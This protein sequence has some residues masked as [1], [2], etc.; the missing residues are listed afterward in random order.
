M[1]DHL[2]LA[3]PDVDAT[4]AQVMR[5]WGVEVVA[6]GSHTGRGT[7]NA[8]AGL[9]AG[10]YLEIVGPDA[11]QPDPPFPRPFGVD[12]LEAPA[13]VAW[14]ARPARPLAEVVGRIAARGVDL[15]PISGMSRVRP[16]GVEL[17]WRLTFP[18]L[19]EP[20]LGTLPF[21]IDWLGSP[22]PTGSLPHGAHLTRLHIV[23]PDAELV[24][25]LLEE[26]G[27]T[28]A[29][30]VDQGPARLWAELH[31]PMGDIRF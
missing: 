1:I 6:G 24:R 7:R 17:N 8:L 25:T 13:L 18:L 15:G 3:T 2:V 10:V 20:Y 27:Q 12:D 26:I 5:D 4:A 16:D 9:G 14:C 30:E 23:H 31:T 28:R 22:H 21:L 29:I 19:A 11:G